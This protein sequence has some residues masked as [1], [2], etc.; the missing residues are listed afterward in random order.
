MD[1]FKKVV[2]ATFFLVL[3]FVLVDISFASL[4]P[5]DGKLTANG[6]GKSTELFFV[7]AVD[8]ATI[9]PVGGS[10]YQ[11]YFHKIRDITYV[12]FSPE[13]IAGNMT[14][15]KFTHEIWND[16]SK[17]NASII[18]AFSIGEKKKTYVF[19]LDNPRYNA[20][21]GD[22]VVDA[23]SFGGKKLPAFNSQQEVKIS[24]IALWIDDVSVNHEAL[25]EMPAV[26]WTPW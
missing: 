20:A 25:N 6:K 17:L 3:S 15:G 14:P 1:T 10:N 7:A 22:F 16:K 21:S 19:Q 18:A 9:K 13:K 12:S 24:D 5:H 26:S 2:F 4:T 8:N 11:I 23:V